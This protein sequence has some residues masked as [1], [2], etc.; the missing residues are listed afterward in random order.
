MSNDDSKFIEIWNRVLRAA[1]SLPGARIDRVDFLRK[2]L[3]KHFPPEVVAKAIATRPACAGIPSS[4]ITSIAKGSIAWHRAGVSVVSFTVGLPGGWW[5]AGTVPADMTQFFW[6]VV[7]ILQKLAYLY[8]WPEF[9]GEEET[10]D[11]T[12]LIMTVFVGVMFGAGAAS[13]ILGDIAEKIGEQIIKR[14]PREALTKWGLYQVAKEVAK[15]LGVKL[16][17]ASFAKYLARIIPVLSGFISGIITWVSF[18]MMSKR[19]R[20]HLEELRLA[21]CGNAEPQDQVDV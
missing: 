16:T 17:K 21:R 9:F 7:V 3:S 18:S 15:W 8:G 2:E 14:L 5:I 20:M 10:D 6:H 11:Q 4:A 1:L 13:K 19:L 12:R